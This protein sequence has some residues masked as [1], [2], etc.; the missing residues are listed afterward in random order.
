MKNTV[1]MTIPVV[2]ILC[3]E[4]DR[5]WCEIMELI[6]ERAIGNLKLTSAGTVR[7]A[8]ILTE[9]LSFDFYIFD[10]RLP[11]GT[12]IELSRKI[13]EADS[14]TPIIFYSAMAREIDKNEAFASGANEYLVKPNDLDKFITTVKHLLNN[15]SRPNPGG[16]GM[17]NISQ[18]SL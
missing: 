9:N 6:L 1:N 16:Y 13:R 3:V 4:D 2:R 18:P 11:D 12:G 7:E 15:A 14:T 8:L 5:D 17:A 10:Y